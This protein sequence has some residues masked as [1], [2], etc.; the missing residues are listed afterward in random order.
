MK[1]SPDA[2]GA[3]NQGAPRDALRADRVAMSPALRCVILNGAEDDTP[4]ER[5]PARLH[6]L[7]PL[8]AHGSSRTARS[9]LHAACA[10]S[11]RKWFVIVRHERNRP[12]THGDDG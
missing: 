11:V 2:K 9:G 1:T 12:P 7:L 5:K 6:T 3:S 4:P 10:I 8:G